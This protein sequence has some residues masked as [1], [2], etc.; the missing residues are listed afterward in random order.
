[1]FD[2]NP[3][4]SVDAAFDTYDDSDDYDKKEEALHRSPKANVTQSDLDTIYSVMADL[5]QRMYVL[6]NKF[7]FLAEIVQETRAQSPMEQYAKNRE[8]EYEEGTSRN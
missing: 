7:A 6:E 5:K 4:A 3:F 2:I 1:M 8:Q